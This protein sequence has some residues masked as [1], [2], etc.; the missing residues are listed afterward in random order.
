MFIAGVDEGKRF[1]GNRRMIDQRLPR[2]PGAAVGLIRQ[3]GPLIQTRGDGGDIGMH[4]ILRPEGGDTWILIIRDAGQPV[5]IGREPLLC[6][7]G[8]GLGN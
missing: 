7:P 5:D 8:R 6:L 2:L 4:A 1:A 3:A